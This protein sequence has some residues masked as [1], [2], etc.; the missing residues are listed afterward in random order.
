MNDFGLIGLAVMGQ[1][2]ALNIARKGYSVSGYNR[3]PQK[4]EKFIREKV[5]DEQIYPYY[6]IKS[7]VESL[8]KPRK[9]ILMVKAGK[10]VDDMINELL[11]YLD[12]GDLII[13]GGNSYFKDTT[14][15]IKELGEKGILYLGMGVSGGES[16]ALHGPSLMPGG[17][18]EAY[19]IAKDVLLRIAAQ[20]ESGSCCTYV[21]NDSAGHFVKMVHNGIEYAIMQSISEVYDIMRK[22]LKLSSEEIGNIFEEW[23]NGELNSYLMEI[24]YKIMKYKDEKT[25]RPLVELILDEA[26]QK[27]TGKWTAETSLDLGVPTPSLNLAVEGRILSFFKDERIKISK[28]V[29]KKY[30]LMDLDKDKVIEDLK[31][32]LIFTIFVSFS[33]GLWL[34]SE[35]S[36]VYNY[37]V[38]L[39]EVLRIW[40]GGCIVRAKILD[41]LREI[42]NEDRENSNL[43][44]S[45]KSASFLQ[46]KLESVKYV[47]RLAKDFYIPTLVINSSLDYFLS[48]A[49][50]NLP[51]NLIQ[52]QRDF[53]GAHTYRRI[54][55]KGIF[56]T[57]WEQE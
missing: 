14:R 11:P 44:D 26:E 12:K 9:I 48:L 41:F 25:G 8:K 2:L 40:K 30:H 5:K 51:A 7:F 42:L 24:S 33:Q 16:G 46:E 15:R 55:E 45:E 57:E 56:H 10:P 29:E 32:S 47:T 54:D 37:N 3:S 52:G 22:V 53:F 43:L 38:D 13:D 39:S 34:I 4:T 19:E 31:N 1:N 27:G 20:T 21:G 17:S 50:E 28:R 36:K 49:E 18:K 35:A 23:N 6:D